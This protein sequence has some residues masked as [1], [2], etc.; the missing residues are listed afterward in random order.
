MKVNSVINMS[1]EPPPF[2]QVK[3]N[4]DGAIKN[5]YK[6]IGYGGLRRNNDDNLIKGFSQN[7]SDCN[8]TIA[9]A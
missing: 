2:D 9:E 5:Y 6:T 7:L 4:V 8:S 3:L 1:W